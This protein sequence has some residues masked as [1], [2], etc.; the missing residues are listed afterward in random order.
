[1]ISS[2]SY[3]AL[4]G[5]ALTTLCQC[6]ALFDLNGLDNGNGSAPEAGGMGGDG[7]D[8][9]GGTDS[10]VGADIGS[11]AD[12]ADA[13]DSASGEDGGVGPDAGGQADGE[14]GSDATA[15]GDGRSDG[16]TGSDAVTASDRPTDADAAGA[17]DGEGGSDGGDVTAGLIVY[18]PFDET[19]GTTAADVS[20]NGHTGTLH[21]GATW[22]AGH[23]AGAVSLDGNNGY[24]S[25]PNGILSTTSNFTIATWVRLNT[26][27]NW[28][29]VFD[30]G[31]GTN[32][33]MFLTAESGNG[34]RLAITTNGFGN[35]QR[36]DGPSLATGAWAH[37]AVTLNGS[38]G[39]FYVNG[40]S[41]ATNS[42][43]TLNASS[44]GVTTQTWLGRSA[45]NNDPY[46]DG[47]LDDFR[48]YNRALTPAEVQTLAK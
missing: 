14:G 41:A 13:A 11:S 39:T 32:T 38:L 4:V 6:S 45:F 20:G 18:Y 3:S 23:R 25:L 12:A 9:G 40:A 19:S 28:M 17:V 10:A 46:L 24:V 33:Y 26:I 36:I 44:L 21:G 30:F 47:L 22:A 29:R 48:I 1:M 16:A 31:T 27:A 5:M 43:M 35:E 2:K 7:N 42:A 34:M 15:G 37:V 8:A